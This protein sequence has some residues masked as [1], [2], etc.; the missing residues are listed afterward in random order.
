MRPLLLP[1]LFFLCTFG[2]FA[3]SVQLKLASDV[4]PPFTNVEGEKAFASDLVENALN[5]KGN[6]TSTEILAFED[7][8]SS[9][10][11]G[12]Y[13][14][15]AALWKSPEREEFLLFSM[16]YLQNQLI[17]VGRKGSDV[18]ASSL[19]DLKGKKVAVVG[20]Y[21][22]GEQV[23]SAIDIEFVPGESDQANLESLLKSEV[24]Y[25][26][27]D[28]LLIQ[29]MLLYQQEEVATYLEVGA[30]PLV[31][32]SLHF[33]LRKDLPDAQKII[34]GFNEEIMKMVVD[35]SYNR[36]LKLNWINVD[37]DGDGKLE[38]VLNG[39]AGNSAP[40]SSYNVYLQNTPST[41]SSSGGYYV[42]GNK[43]KNWDNVP[44]Q[45][46]QPQ[47]SQEDMGKVKILNFN[48]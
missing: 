42:G 45:Y 3:Q 2:A 10:K 8:L 40:T 14:G 33:A 35:G 19:S 41:L 15:S 6:K 5:R 34:D 43:Y 24:E 47:V 30:V 28:A 44:Q 29:N 20:S 7:V 16:P 9:L 39:K 4:W 46:K 32:R 21:A 26:L 1:I 18:S 12:T 25:M 13:D 17:L 11:D 37:I 31:V 48:F 23:E 27:V 22:Y 36:I 38:M